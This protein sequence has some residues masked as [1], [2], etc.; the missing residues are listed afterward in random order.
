VPRTFDGEAQHVTCRLLQTMLAPFK[1]SF[2]PLLAKYLPQRSGYLH[3]SCRSTKQ[4]AK[5]DE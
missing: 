2:D 3:A 1:C 4:E 5:D